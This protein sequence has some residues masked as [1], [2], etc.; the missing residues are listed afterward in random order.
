MR[1]K[2]GLAAIILMAASSYVFP[3]AEVV[4]RPI[5]ADVAQVHDDGPLA[6]GEFDANACTV[7]CPRH[8]SLFDL[9]SGRPKTLPASIFVVSKKSSSMRP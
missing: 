1:N 9:Q 4:D 6:E 3:Q 7:E 8:G 2:A 5:G